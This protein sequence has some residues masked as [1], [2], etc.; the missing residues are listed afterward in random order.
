MDLGFDTFTSTPQCAP[1]ASTNCACA[2]AA[3]PG[4]VSIAKC[5]TG[6]YHGNPD[7]ITFPC[8]QYY[9]PANFPAAGNNGLGSTV[10]Q[11]PAASD[12]DDNKFLMDRTFDFMNAS[13]AEGKPFLAVVW[14]HSVH[15]PYI[16][17]NA[18]RGM[19]AHLKDENQADYY[20]AL[21]GERAFLDTPP[22]KNTH[23]TCMMHLTGRGVWKR[24]R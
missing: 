13:I 2:Q 9:K 8:Q 6:H 15:I 5:N 12:D 23:C 21:T 16:S 22:C 3:E 18:F 10:E 19:Y 17:P 24:S 14:F 1:S 7:A 4:P 20:G 11:W